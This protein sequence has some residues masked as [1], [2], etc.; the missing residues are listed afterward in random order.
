MAQRLVIDDTR[1]VWVKEYRG[2]QRR[3][4]LRALDAL[5]RGLRI[6]AL[7]PPPHHAGDDAKAIEM[8]RIDELRRLDVRVPRVVGEGSRMLV[9]SDTGASLSRTLK[10]ETDPARRDAM[11]ARAAAALVDVHRRGACVGQPLPRNMTIDGDT[12]GFLDFEEDPLEV[13]SLRDA[14]VR[15]WMLFAYGFAPFHAQRP[16]R[17]AELL[18]EGISQVDQQVA[19]GVRDAAMRLRGLGACLRPFLAADSRLRIALRSMAGLVA[20]TLIVTL[21]FA[22]DFL[23]DGDIDLLAPVFALGAFS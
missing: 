17:L 21:V 20:T 22:V 4:L 19:T 7:R 13:L 15:D 2:G 3:L 14:Q 11:I 9:L 18:A 1:P 10:Q 8:R 6:E 5:A 16:Q 12:I 23:H